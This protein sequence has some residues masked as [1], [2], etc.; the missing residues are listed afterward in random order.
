[1]S[2]LTIGIHKL[3]E[4]WCED[5]GDLDKG[6][7]VFHDGGT[8][9]CITCAKGLNDPEYEAAMERYIQV[10]KVQEKAEEEA[11]EFRL[12]DEPWCEHCGD[13]PKGS[14]VWSD[15]GTHWCL[16]CC[17]TFDHITKAMI[18]EA[19]K[20]FAPLVSIRLYK[21]RHKET[22]LFSVGGGTPSWTKLGK[23]WSSLGT[24]RSHIALYLVSSCDEKYRTSKYGW[25]RSLPESVEAEMLKNWQIVEVKA[26]FW[27]KDFLKPASVLRESHGKTKAASLRTKR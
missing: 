11:G 18:R 27:E 17:T 1:M 25:G 21:I 2:E 8:C 15:G 19:E 4:P 6:A 26:D 5:C 20:K 3:D 13:L 9:W 24:L 10:R 23:T 14:I 22:G 7:L 12:L 16:S